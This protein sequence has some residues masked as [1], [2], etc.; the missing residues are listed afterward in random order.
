V[1]RLL[2]AAMGGGDEGVLFDLLSPAYG[3][4]LA[5]ACVLALCLPPLWACWRALARRWR[6]WV[7][8]AAVS[9][10][11]LPILPVPFLDRAWYGAWIDGGIALPATFGVP[12]SVWAVEVSV[13]LVLAIAGK[14]VSRRSFVGAASAASFPSSRGDAAKKARG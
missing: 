9:L 2:T 12:W 1:L 8:A 6:L 4:W 14:L 11:M 13:A 10:P 7:F 3:R 5:T